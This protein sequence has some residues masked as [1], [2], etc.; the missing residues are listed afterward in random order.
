M[1]DSIQAL[2]RAD[3]EAREKLGIERYGTALR[4]HNGRDAL[5]DAYEEALDMA[6]YLK[7]ALVERG[8]FVPAHVSRVGRA[9]D[10]AMAALDVHAAGTVLDHGA[11]LPSV[12]SGEHLVNLCG[13]AGAHQGLE[14]TNEWDDIV[15]VAVAP[16]PARL[17]ANALGLASID[18]ASLN[19][20]VDAAN[21]V[22]IRH[23]HKDT[24][25]RSRRA[26]LVVAYGE[27]EAPFPLEEAGEPRE[28]GVFHAAECTA[29]SCG[30]PVIEGSREG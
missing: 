14:Q 30:A 5:L 11:P 7:Q 6:S 26:I 12:D 22:L 25:E 15:D 4:A 29:E 24:D 19:D 10:G 17:P 23:G 16:G 13:P 8:P 1:T 2:V 27:V 18:R 28:V 3:L 9:T 20:L 21:H